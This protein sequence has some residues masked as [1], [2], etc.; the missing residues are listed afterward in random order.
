M[1]KLCFFV[2]AAF[3]EKVK[4]AVFE[5]GAGR[6]GNYKEC[7]WQTSGQ[8]QFKPLSAANPFIGTQGQLERVEELRVELL[9][10]DEIIREAVCELKKAHPYECP[11]YDVVK[12]EEI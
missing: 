11:A 2:P 8:G 7:A 9:C 3:A 1:Y 5:T 12:L 10:R 4:Q 6:L